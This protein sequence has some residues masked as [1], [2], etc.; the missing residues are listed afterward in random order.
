MSIPCV[1]IIVPV[2]AGG[3]AVR[4]SL[5][6]LLATP[7]GANTD[8]VVVNDAIDDA[9]LVAH[10]RALA[11][12]NQLKLLENA[13]PHGFVVAVNHALALHP[14]RDVVVLHAGVEL[15]PG[16]LP[17]LVAHAESSPRIGAIAAFADRDGVVNYPRPDAVNALPEGYDVARLDALF[18]AANAGRHVVMPAVSGPCVYLR[19]ETLTATGVLDGDAFASGNTAEEDLCLRASAVGF[20]H[21]LAGDVFVG[22][23]DPANAPEA[24]AG[25]AL[26]RLYP[27]YPAQ[28]AQA[29]R[30]AQ[31]L[32]RRVDMLRLAASPRSKLVFIAHPWGGGVRRHMADLAELV[33]DECE[34]L[35]LEPV[36][37]ATVRLHWPKAGEDFSAHFD[38]PDGLPALARTLTALGVARLHFHHIHLHPA[39]VLDLPAATGLPYDCT[40]HDYYAICPQYH[41][42]D[43]DGRYCGEPDAAGCAACLARRPG[44]W[45]LDIGEWRRRFAALFAGAERVIA[46]SNDIAERIRRYC[47]DLPL[48]VWSHPERDIVMP[49]RSLRVALLGT[50]SPEKGL[51]VVA[52]CAA[53]ARARSL[54]LTF[55]IIGS[56]TEPIAQAPTTSLTIYGQYDD[57]DLARLLVDERPDVIWFPAQVPESYSYTLSV[58]LASGLPVVAS[59]LGALPERLAGYRGAVTLPWDASSSDWNAALLAVADVARA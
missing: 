25:K 29:R 58:A 24:S 3:A 11:V 28:A 23:A 55:R 52:A 59:K 46:P 21:L 12:A 26:A 57:A 22:H 6:R 20:V 44:L 10:L 18:Q 43:A 53:D 40:L 56:T 9:D 47:P 33:A 27:E 49:A 48:E 30:S 45:G 38:L 36:S 31:P 13:S 35:T 54:P 15:P 16:W 5:D 42:V 41:L 39:A 32:A 34:V 1:D 37:G 19:R 17:R 51:H 4:R 8:I 7:H 14:E 50:L 2:C